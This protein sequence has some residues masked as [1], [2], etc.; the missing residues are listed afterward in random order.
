MFILVYQNVID[1][2]AVNFPVSLILGAFMY[3][4]WDFRPSWHLHLGTVISSFSICMPFISF[5]Y[6]I[7]LA[8]TSGMM[9]KSSNERGHPC[10]VSDLSRK[11]SS[12]SP[13]SLMLAIGICRCSLSS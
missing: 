8:R 12:I 4:S 5:S 13:L 9:L 11:V 7:A 2:C 6:H 1:L 3:N 10:L